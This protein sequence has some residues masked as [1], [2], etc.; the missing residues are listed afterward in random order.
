MLHFVA[1][2]PPYDA[3]MPHTT[4]IVLLW[5]MSAFGREIPTFIGI[6]DF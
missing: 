2:Q 3:V 4:Q 1:P 5:L 6:L